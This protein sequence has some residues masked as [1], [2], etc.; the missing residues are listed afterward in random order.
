MK[1]ENWQSVKELVGDEYRLLFWY[2]VQRSVP[3]DIVAEFRRAV[4]VPGRVG[5]HVF[6]A[7]NDRFLLRLVGESVELHRTQLRTGLD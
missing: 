1:N 2:F 6:E 4:L 7:A 3:V 5:V